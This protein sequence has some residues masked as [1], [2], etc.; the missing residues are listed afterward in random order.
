MY[1]WFLLLLMLPYSKSSI[2]ASSNHHLNPDNRTVKTVRLKIQILLKKITVF[3]F[4]NTFTL[5]QE[6]LKREYLWNTIINKIVRLILKK[7]QKISIILYFLKEYFIHKG[8]GNYWKPDEKKSKLLDL[9]HLDFV[10]CS[11]IFVYFN[12][13]SSCNLPPEKN[14]IFISLY[15]M[16]IADD[17]KPSEWNTFESSLRVWEICTEIP[18]H[19]V[20]LRDSRILQLWWYC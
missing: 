20:C 9:V 18:W 14:P 10:L 1:S 19:R 4:A 8:A 12:L 3:Y 13:D 2:L 6:K 17:I 15:K 7:T 11:N 5:I 16:K